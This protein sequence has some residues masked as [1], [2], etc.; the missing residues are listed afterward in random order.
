MVVYGFDEYSQ[1]RLVG[2]LQLLHSTPYFWT[3]FE[4]SEKTPKRRLR[5]NWGVAVAVLACEYCARAAHQ[6]PQKLNK[7]K[8]HTINRAHG[9]LGQ[10]PA[11]STVQLASLPTKPRVRDVTFSCRRRSSL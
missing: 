10:T 5:A 4:N 7:N 9:A 3:Y 8:P 6:K 11:P 1:A 2:S